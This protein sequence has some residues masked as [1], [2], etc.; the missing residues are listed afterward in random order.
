M[1]AQTIE[2][3][4]FDHNNINL[5]ITDKYMEVFNAN[6]SPYPISDQYITDMYEN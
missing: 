1:S 3:L 2:F 5:V 6:Q 4:N